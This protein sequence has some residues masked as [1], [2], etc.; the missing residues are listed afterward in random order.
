MLSPDRPRA[1][2]RAV[3]VL[4][5][6][7]FLQCV[8]RRPEAVVWDGEHATVAG[9]TCVGVHD[10]VLPLVQVVEDVLPE[11]EVPAVD[12]HLHIGHWREPG[13]PRRAVYV[14]DMKGVLG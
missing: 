2:S 5:P 8:H 3:E 4:K 12:P 11:N 7:P 1:L 14:D 13:D 10:E 6:G 9:R